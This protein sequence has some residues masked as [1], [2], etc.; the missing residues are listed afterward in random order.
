MPI[1]SVEARSRRRKLPNVDAPQVQDDELRRSVEAVREHLRMYEGDSGAPKERFVTIEELE[2]A[3]LIGTKVQRGF[4][5]IDSVLGDP[6]SRSGNQKTTLVGGTG[7]KDYLRDLL[8]TSVASQRQED[9]LVYDSGFWRNFPLFTTENN[10]R[11]DQEY[12]SSSIYFD[13]N[14]GIDFLH[15]DAT[16]RQ[17][18][19]LTTGFSVA[20]GGGTLVALVDF[21]DGAG[22]NLGTGSDA[23]ILSGTGSIADTDTTFGTY[24][25][26]SGSGGTSSAAIVI[27]QAATDDAD[28]QKWVDLN[29]G[30]HVE[31][32]WKPDE[33]AGSN[34]IF[35]TLE[36]GGPRNFSIR[37][38]SGNL[39]VYV[40]STS[41]IVITAP[42]S[43][44]V[45]GTWYHVACTVDTSN[46][47][48]LWFDGVY[49]GQA[50]ISGVTWDPNPNATQ[51]A[52]MGFHEGRVDNIRVIAGGYVYNG[53]ENFTPP[54]VIG[55]D[56]EELTLGDTGYP[57]VLDGSLT[58]HR[59]SIGFN[60]ENDDAE[61]IE[62]LNFTDDTPGTLTTV[63]D[64]STAT[65][66]T[67]SVRLASFAE[68]YPVWDFLDGDFTMEFWGYWE[69][70]GTADYY[71][72]S[73]DWSFSGQ[74]VWYWFWDRSADTFEFVFTTDGTTRQAA[75]FGGAPT[76]DEWHFFQL[77][78]E[79][80]DLTMWVDGVQNGSTYNIGSSVIFPYSDAGFNFV[81]ICNSDQ[82]FGPFRGKM[83]ELRITKGF[84]RPTAMPTKAFP[85]GFD[86]D[87]W[88]YV[89][90]C[91]S[92][93]DRLVL[94]PEHPLDVGDDS[95]YGQIVTISSGFSLTSTTTKWTETYVAD[96][97]F[98]TGDPVYPQICDAQYLEIRGNGLEVF[99]GLIVKDQSFFTLDVKMF[100]DL[101]VQ[102]DELISGDLTVQGTTATFNANIDANG[103]SDFLGTVDIQNLLSA[104]A[105]AY[106]TNELR[107]YD[108]GGTDYI[109]DFHNGVNA[110]RSFTNT[111]TY[112]VLS[113]DVDINKTLI[114][115]PTEAM[116]GVDKS[117][118]VYHH[119]TGLPVPVIESIPDTT[120]AGD[121]YWG[122]TV[123][124]GLFEG[125]DEQVTY[126]S[127]DSGARTATFGG[128]AKLDSAVTPKF[129]ATTALLTDG[130]G[131]YVS[132]PD[133]DDW[134]F[135]D[136]DFTI[137]GWL[138]F[139]SGAGTT[140]VT[141]I[142][143]YSATSNAERGW[144]TLVSSTG[145]MWFVGH[146]DAVGGN[147]TLITSTITGWANATWYHLAWVRDSVNNE[148]RFYRD[149]TLE[150]T[151]TLSGTTFF[152]NAT[153]A[154]T[155]GARD[156]N[157]INCV[158]GLT[159]GWRITKGVQRYTGASY[160][161]PTAAFPTAATPVDVW[162][163]DQ[164][165][166]HTIRLTADEFEVNAPMRVEERAA[167]PADDAGYG[168]LWV[169]N[170]TPNNLMFTD[171]AG[172]DFV[173]GGSGATSG[174]SG[175]VANDQVV[176]G[177]GAST[178]DSSANLTFDG[179]T[180][181]VTSE[182][183]YDASLGDKISFYDDRIGLTTGYNI[184]V[185]GNHLYFKSGG[186]PGGYRWYI[187]RNAD[188]GTTDNME[189]T[190]TTLTLQSELFVDNEDV[191][192]TSV[193]FGAVEVKRQSA[194][195]AAAIK[196]S[197]S[198][199]IKGY[200]GF[201]DAEDFIVWDNVLG[202]TARVDNTGSL[203]LSE[204]ASSASSVAA[205]G[206]LWVKSDTPN[207]LYFTD[208]AGTNW[209]LL[210]VGA[211][212]QTITAG[213]T[214]GSGGSITVAASTGIFYTEQ[215]S[216]DAPTAGQ[217]QIWVL[218]STPNMPYYT[219]DDSK[220]WPLKQFVEQEFAYSSTI[221]ATDPGLSTLQFDS[222]TPASITNMYIDDESLSE[223]WGWILSN[224]A[225]GDV[226]QIKSAVDS[227]DYIVASV[228]GTPTDNTGWWTVP[229]TIIHSGTIFTNADQVRLSVQWLSQA[230]GGAQTPWTSD[231]DGGGF[232]LDNID[233][234][235]I[236]DS[237]GLDTV[238]FTHDGTDF[239]TAFVT[240]TDWNITGL[241]G[242]R[243]QDGAEFQIFNATNADSLTVSVTTGGP[244][245]FSADVNDIQF[246]NQRALIIDGSFAPAVRIKETSNIPTSGA[247]YGTFYVNADDNPNRPWFRDESGARVPIDIPS[248]IADI[249]LVCNTSTTHT[250]ATTTEWR[251]NNA[252]QA[253]ATAIAFGTAP[254]GMD[255]LHGDTLYGSLA[256]INTVVTIIQYDDASRWRRY[257]LTSAATDN[258]TNYSFSC[259]YIDGGFAI[260]TSKR[261]IIQF[262]R[263]GYFIEQA[264]IGTVVAGT[265]TVWVKSDTPNTLMFTDDAGT[266]FVIGGASAGT[267]V[268][269]GTTTDA[270]LRWSGSAWV[271]EAS[272]RLSTTGS[273]F[274]EGKTTDDTD[275]TG[276]AQLW[277][278]SSSSRYTPTWTTPAGTVQILSTM[279][280]T[281]QNSGYVYFYRTDAN[282]AI[283]VR[284][285]STTG[286]YAR[287]F[288]SGFAGA[289]SGTNFVDIGYQNAAGGSIKMTGTLTMLERS[290]AA[291]DTTAYGQIWVR[292][293]AS[294]QTLMF[295]EDDGTDHEIV[296]NLTAPTQLWVGTDAT[297]PAAGTAGRV[298]FNSD[299]GKLNI[300]D[301]T[302][303]TLPDGTTT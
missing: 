73:R 169:R 284:Q 196:Y 159:E 46:I 61:R 250:S 211:S 194:T 175:T 285:A 275:V 170:D 288:Q 101:E 187:A 1:D 260:L 239:N 251:V 216:D 253:S 176:V 167:A 179:T 124:L 129:N 99:G 273:I 27:D 106:V 130:T 102:G 182:I 277:A 112:K 87:Y 158:N 290:A 100:A 90:L 221:T 13:E 236:Q 17:H 244:V 140:N 271:E 190:E 297:R 205:Y 43:V 220:D 103:N 219:G 26:Y 266:D 263:P 37:Y 47:I 240:T 119:G 286:L 184:G 20:S 156:V 138:Y 85:R 71:F 52:F 91:M 195:N 178:V 155:V 258:S 147:V 232:G 150:E 105:D 68:G 45:D 21:E 199:G 160:T 174:L 123:F 76:A 139:T 214:T 131:D 22:G 8:D 54:T 75:V 149:G 157:A 280:N 67:D 295:T 110:Y 171:D 282:P 12:S 15:P 59:N 274:L 7:G 293:G 207:V 41:N 74:R 116:V 89:I 164:A 57:V 223:D 24:C 77:R 289:S 81:R 162:F 294:I 272:G 252:N 279:N 227:A 198:D 97:L 39:N 65:T 259:T 249:E 238:T 225:D 127:D 134:W 94:G 173:I 261:C 301:G 136:D 200:A 303:W 210:D 241:G 281:D 42:V 292:D 246:T 268:A 120:E 29:A 267:G 222:L 19:T 31:F 11:A 145:Q 69:D 114:I 125:A 300:D 231:I 270:M 23:Y 276:F 188:N 234:L 44:A 235:E 18:V 36:G 152:H 64:G 2:L 51:W 128:N 193:N 96:D 180:L 161:V 144:Y 229:L 262:E 53:N 78:R 265:G 177:T 192:F 5:L 121:P 202:I 183:V 55:Q 108:S 208:D 48:R 40:G 218:N 185:E 186:T 133:S 299:D 30:Y 83:Q 153:G 151:E 206:Q 63:L 122:A 181:G 117:L 132:F 38:L 70:L 33:L 84:A 298:F 247:G 137:E 243:L 25:G 4:A 10:W 9:F 166:G 230:G 224:L 142:A 109:S 98:F 226:I 111:T 35:Q 49:Q 168:Q 165:G 148:L 257:R 191:L 254:V 62:L 6:V 56:L 86:D 283:Y 50:D 237:T 209:N 302:N 291:N 141:P 245:V 58:T 88:P 16:R 32:H 143:Q 115:S 255:G 154:L 242:L 126:T 14:Y 204:R 287:F 80:A 93:D 217:G 146:T 278:N 79:G 233:R 203:F 269:A 213:W 34:Y 66:I 135:G 189:L 72:L 264:S 201:N 95:L 3:G 60:W 92:F 118:D 296:A 248:G 107:I 172:T 197:N 82:A 215:A 256:P 228:N 212:T 163:G 113:A 28:L 104:N